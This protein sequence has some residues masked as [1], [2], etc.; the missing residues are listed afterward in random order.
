MS[1]SVVNAVKNGKIVSYLELS[2]HVREILTAK[3]I[4]K[5]PKTLGN[6][7]EDFRS[8]E[9]FGLTDKASKYQSSVLAIL[10]G[11][12]SREFS[13]VAEVVKP[14]EWDETK[15]KS[16][17]IIHARKVRELSQIRESLAVKESEVKNSLSNV[18]FT[19]QAKFT[20]MLADLQSLTASEITSLENSVTE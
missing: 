13:E 14:N 12:Q 9:F 3:H 6:R 15:L 8:A 5:L 1:E 17:A 4:G 2:G 19:Q 11:L 10:T 20:Q 7:L 16:K 18:P